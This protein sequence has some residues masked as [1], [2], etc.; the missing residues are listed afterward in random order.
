MTICTGASTHANSVVSRALVNGGIMPSSNLGYL[1]L[2]EIVLPEIL[3]FI[4]DFR[5]VIGDHTQN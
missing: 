3:G 1:F 5:K 2:A 4:A